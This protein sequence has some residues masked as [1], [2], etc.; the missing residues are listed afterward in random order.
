MGI[1]HLF[2]KTVIISRLKDEGG[3][4]VGFNATA[5]VDV[6]VQ[7]LAPEAVAALQLTEERAWNMY[8]D[9]E[10]VEKIR[11]GDMIALVD[12]LG[13]TRYYKVME[14]TV[15][16]YGINQHVESIIVQYDDVRND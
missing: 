9:I 14:K 2:D 16:N 1:A 15:K 10:D 8:S 6:A 5:T 7:E 12:D 11:S 4:K 3:S 13:T